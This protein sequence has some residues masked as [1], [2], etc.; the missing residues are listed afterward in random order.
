MM[1]ISSPA[2]LSIQ[3]LSP[4]NRRTIGRSALLYDGNVFAFWRLA[5]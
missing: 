5:G 2:S 1:E 3:Q 4:A